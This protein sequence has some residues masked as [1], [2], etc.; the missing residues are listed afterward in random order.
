MDGYMSSHAIIFDMDDTLVATAAIW[1]VAEE[2]LLAACGQAWTADLALQYKGMNSLDV[3]ATIH[4]IL[5]PGLSCAE[6]QRIMRDK[7]LQQ[8]ET[9]PVTQMAGA[10]DCVRN[11]R[12]I[13]PMAVA[14]GSP[15]AGIQTALRR[16]E[17]LD[18]FDLVVTSESV[19]RGKPHPDV[20]LETARQLGVKPEH[21]LVFED[22]LVGVQAACA[23]GM[24]SFAVPSSSSNHPAIAER[25][26]RT[27]SSLCDVTPELVRRTLL[28]TT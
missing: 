18:C 19:P 5:R 4:R 21:C 6:C 25:A 14:S 23:A 13:A 24:K 10:V 28:G 3:A 17:I 16:L 8:Y 11:L 15:L 22:S 2:T 9:I 20:F 7:L 26:T 1:R 12:G 27:F